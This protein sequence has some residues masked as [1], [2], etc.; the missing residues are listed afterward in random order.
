MRYEDLT[1]LIGEILA[2]YPGDILEKSAEAAFACELWTDRRA[3]EIAIMDL[4]GLRAD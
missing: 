2:S 4:C 3:R 1:P